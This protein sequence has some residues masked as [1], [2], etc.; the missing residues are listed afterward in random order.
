MCRLVLVS[1][2]IV[3]SVMRYLLA[4]KLNFV[5]NPFMLEFEEK[6]GKSSNPQLMHYIRSNAC[7]NW[8]LHRPVF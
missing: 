4:I 2:E 6:V 7:L 8:T 1:I 5:T 3:L